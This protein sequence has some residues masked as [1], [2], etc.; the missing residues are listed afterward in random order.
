MILVWDIP[1]APPVKASRGNW[2]CRTMQAGEGMGISAIDLGIIYIEVIVKMIVIRSLRQRAEAA[3]RGGLVCWDSE[4]EIKERKCLVEEKY[5]QAVLE[6]K[7][8]MF[9][10]G[11]GNNANIG[12]GL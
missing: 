12:G 2:K 1:S 10:G 5:E 8:N 11:G 6:A 7:G 3:K 4:E 9:R